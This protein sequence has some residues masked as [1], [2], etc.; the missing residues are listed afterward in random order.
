MISVTILTKNSEKHLKQVLE[1][2]A[3]FPEVILFDNGSEDRTFEIAQ[4]FNNV[5]I[6]Q[7][8]FKGFGATHNE[9]SSHASHDW[10]LSVD[11]DEILTPELVEEIHHLT[12]N[13][14]NVYSI[15][16]Q[17]FYRG[18][19]IRWCGW[20]PDRQYKLYYRKTTS[21]CTS[22]VHESIRIE[23]LFPIPL[24]HHL[25]HYPYENIRDF[26]EKMQ[27]YSDLFARQYQGKR[28]STLFTAVSHSAF[29]FFKSYFLKRGILG[30]KE[31]FEISAYNAI[32]AFYKYLKL[33]EYNRK[34]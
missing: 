12:L 7:G 24:K 33:S 26:L 5:K 17:N 14:R 22:Q 8:E 10:I 20:Y 34:I 25:K 3:S 4:E 1:S 2:T 16:R 13:T 23:Q 18:K 27:R 15:P 28:K 21:Y 31:G 9:A 29:T 6:I 11:S 32:T 19:W 30:G